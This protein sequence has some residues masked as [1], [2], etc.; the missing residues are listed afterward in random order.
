MKSRRT[1]IAA[2]MG[3]VALGAIAMLIPPVRRRVLHR[4][5][6]STQGPKTVEDRLAEFTDARKRI[7][8]KCRTA[9]VTFPPA[10]VVLLGLKDEKRIEVYATRKAEEPMRHV[11]SYPILA[12][13][14][15][16]G[17]KLREGDKQVP[18]GVYPVELL[19]PNSLFHVSLRVGYP[20]TFDRENAAREGRTNLGGDI[21]I[22]GGDESIG[23][24]AMGDPAAE[25]LFVLAALAGIDNVRIVIAPLDLR[26]RELPTGLDGGW[27]SD[28]Y[29]S[30]RA[31]L[32]KLTQ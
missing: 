14:G 21:M 25:D 27:H 19:N 6:S 4:F 7:E 11:A 9:G 12:A 8:A 29:T 32:A 23:C 20:N 30:I 2:A 18:E 13:S 16:A 15:V 1:I 22:H 10:R 31:E 3:A 17:P 28:L 5:F 24:L 26:T